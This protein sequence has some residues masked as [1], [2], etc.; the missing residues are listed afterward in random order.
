M[1]DLYRGKNT[2]D[3]RMCYFTSI[4]AWDIGFTVMVL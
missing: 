3:S 2:N 4:F 1:F